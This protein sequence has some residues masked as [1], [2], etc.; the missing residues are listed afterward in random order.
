MIL[1]VNHKLIILLFKSDCLLKRFL[2]FL[3]DP[4]N[5]IFIRKQLEIKKIKKLNINPN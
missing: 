5:S 4:E 3:N 1:D 2:R